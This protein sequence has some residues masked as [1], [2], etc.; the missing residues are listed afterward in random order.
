MNLTRKR[1]RKARLRHSSKMVL[2]NATRRGSLFS[3]SCPGLFQYD[4]RNSPAV[5]TA[6]RTTNA[7]FG[8]NRMS[9]VS[10]VASIN[11]HFFSPPSYLLQLHRISS[12]ASAS[13]RERAHIISGEKLIRKQVVHHGVSGDPSL[14]SSE[15]VCAWV[16]VCVSMPSVY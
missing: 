8:I 12:I 16:C 10:A 5:S 15:M 11:S 3:K 2:E 9:S 14:H 4:S 13:S 7:G 6:T 1:E